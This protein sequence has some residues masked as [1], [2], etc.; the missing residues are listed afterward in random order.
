MPPFDKCVNV[1]GNVFIGGIAFG[2]TSAV[3]SLVTSVVFGDTCELA[4]DAII[5]S[6]IIM[7]A[8]IALL[9]TN[10]QKKCK[11]TNLNDYRCQMVR[12][13]S[14]TM[15]GALHCGIIG[16]ACGVAPGLVSRYIFRSKFGVL[17]V[18]YLTAG[19]GVVCGAACELAINL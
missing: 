1:V 13:T 16:A 11:Y 19:I 4:D 17:K 3:S 12:T 15:T 2:C 6:S 18:C 8:G 5:T 7:G 9:C 10:K 14:A